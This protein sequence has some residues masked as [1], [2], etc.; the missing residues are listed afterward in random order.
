VV[1][2]FRDEDVTAKAVDFKYIGH[3]DELA[4][5]R[6]EEEARVGFNPER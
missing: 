5:A 1:E 2:Q 4:V 6:R 3:D